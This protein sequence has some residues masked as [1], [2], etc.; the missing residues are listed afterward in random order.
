MDKKDRW[1]GLFME[2]WQFLD[3]N[4]KVNLSIYLKIRG[5]HGFD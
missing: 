5:K 1:M 2:K 3:D 4:S